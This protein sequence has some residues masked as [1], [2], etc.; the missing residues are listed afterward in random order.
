M[1]ALKFAIFPATLAIFVRQSKEEENDEQHVEYIYKTMFNF[2]MMLLKKL[3]TAVNRETIDGQL[4]ISTSRA[5]AGHFSS[6]TKINVRVWQS[7]QGIA[8]SLRLQGMS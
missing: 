7:I 1:F 3:I 2:A 8:C 4:T 5:N 6:V